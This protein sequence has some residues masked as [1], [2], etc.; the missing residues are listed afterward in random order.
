MREPHRTLVSTSRGFNGYPAF[1]PDGGTLAF[2]SDRSGRLE[3]YVRPL[4]PGARETPVTSDGQDNVQPAWSPDGRYIAYHSMRRGGLWLVPALG[5]TPRQSHDVRIGPR[6]VAR[7]TAIAFSSLG[8]AS[9][10]GMTQSSAALF[11]LDVA[12]PT[13]RP[14]R[15]G[16]R[17]AGEPP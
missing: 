12:R 1:S 14:S 2:S 6:L 17:R 8:L 15:D 7:R 10:D 9:L 5:G 13:A 3:L 16:S 4:A 11:V